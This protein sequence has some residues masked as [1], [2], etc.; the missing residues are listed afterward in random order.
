[1][2]DIDLWSRDGEQ[3]P[4]LNS[5][6]L[7]YSIFSQLT[8]LS[9]SVVNS[10]WQRC[11]SLSSHTGGGGPGE[12][13]R[14]GGGLK[15]EGGGDGGEGGGGD[16]GQSPQ[17]NV[18]SLTYPK[19]AFPH[20]TILSMSVVNSLWQRCGC[21]SSHTSGGEGAGQSPQLNSQ[22]MT[23][24]LV[25]HLRILSI[26]VANSSWQRCGSLSSHTSGSG[27]GEAQA[28]LR[29]QRNRLSLWLG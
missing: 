28:P 7:T 9:I 22:L 19:V 23:Y 25:P 11:G 8:I 5:Q 1:M 18:Q 17:L 21:L 26:G 10:S 20:L 4:Q 12:G 14:G 13:E 16:G 24:S 29:S 2:I 6:S 3:N 15:G 27:E